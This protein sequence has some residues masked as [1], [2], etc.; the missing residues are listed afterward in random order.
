MG[1]FP[2]LAHLKQQV[3]DSKYVTD[4]WAMLDLLNFAMYSIIVVVTV[5]KSTKQNLLLLLLLLFLH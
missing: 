5:R 2:F 1:F 4:E 3:R